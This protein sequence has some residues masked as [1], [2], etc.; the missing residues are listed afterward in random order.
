MTRTRLLFLS[1]KTSD[2]PAIAMPLIPLKRATGS[3]PSAKPGLALTSRVQ[4][5]GDP[6]RSAITRM[7][8]ASAMYAALPKKATSQG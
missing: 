2:E 8:C 1:V 5:T 3:E 6:V 7:L 4:T